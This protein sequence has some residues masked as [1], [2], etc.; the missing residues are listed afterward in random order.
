MSANV[1]TMFSA[2]KTP[3][4]KLGVVTPDVLT[5]QEALVT[6]GLDWLVAL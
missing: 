2:V 5:S 4:H 1:E 3:W 6:A